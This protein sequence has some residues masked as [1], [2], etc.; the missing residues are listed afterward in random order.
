MIK[1][2]KHLKNRTDHQSLKKEDSFWLEIT[3]FPW[4]WLIIFGVLFIVYGQTLAF[5][6][7]KFDEE[8]I[9]TGNM[10]LLRDFGRMKE[11]LFR[12]A[13]L[14]NIGSDFYRP[15]QNLSFMVDAH[16]SGTEGWG[17]YLMNILIHG[18]TCCILFYLLILFSDNRRNALLLVLFFA[19]APIFVQAIAWVPSR[20]D[21]LIGMFGTFS[22]LSLIKYLRTND[23]RHLAAHILSFLFAMFSKET[24]ILFPVV[25][26]FYYFLMEK[27]KKVSIMGMII[28]V[29]CYIL[30]I[31]IFLYLRNLVINV[32]ATG[33]VFGVLPL[34]GNLRVLPEFI[35]KFILPVSLAPMPGFTFLN[36]SMGIFLA[37]LLVLAVVKNKSTTL[38]M[39]FFGV[40][41]FLLFSLPGIMYR[42]DFGNNAYD[43]L[44]HRAYLPLMGIL[45]VCF[46][47]MNRTENTKAG[48]YYLPIFVLM[49]AGYAIYNY[50]YAKNYQNPLTFYCL[51]IKAN[52]HSALA[53]N[54]LGVI[55]YNSKDYHNAIHEFST[56]ISIKPDYAQAYLNRGNCREIINEKKGAMEDFRKAILYKPVLFQPHYNL[57]NILYDMG[58]KE[59]A[60][61]E[62]NMTLTLYP[63]YTYAFIMRARLRYQFKDYPAA[64]EDLN[65]ILKLNPNDT[66]AYILRGKTNLMLNNREDAYKDWKSALVN[67]SR[68]AAHLLQQYS[69]QK[70]K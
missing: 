22:F 5:F 57:A 15:L 13:F 36:T 50:N 18:T 48:K 42:H 17:Y 11:V 10:N 64:F 65:H 21:L 62:Y 41:W 8:V 6:L 20:G 29:L 47:Q 52:P 56:A 31:L 38:L 39:T 40:G 44:E 27:T 61:K 24:A 23:Y 49:I 68:E 53:Y 46:F 51:A 7:G 19:V 32:P 1:Q 30:I 35:A 58:S 70:S 25:F 2:K 45:M 14:S 4:L 66:Q 69:V 54:N 60:L 34:I 67:G 26:C 16:L 43:Y 59:E 37:G 55:R 3:R 33:K 9:I 12:D 28:P 63:T